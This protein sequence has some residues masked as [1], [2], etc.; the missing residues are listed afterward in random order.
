MTLKHLIHASV[1]AT[2][3]L[4]IASVGVA[5]ED[6][7]GEKSTHMMEH[8]D[9]TLQQQVEAAKS[10]QDHEA[11]A[12]RFEAEAKKFDDAAARHEQLAKHYGYGHGAAPKGNAASMAQHCKN[13]SKNLKASAQDAREMARL[14]RELG[15]ALAK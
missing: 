9:T 10:Q 1:A 15:Q 2:A 12:Q 8:H 6:T 7:K 13:L 4:G 11:I 5:A 3:L 14:H